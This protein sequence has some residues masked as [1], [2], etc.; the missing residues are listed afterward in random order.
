MALRK[1][2]V[3]KLQRIP[4][5]CHNT[6]RIIDLRTDADVCVTR[7]IVAI[8]S[9]L[10]ITPVLKVQDST[11]RCEH[12]DRLPAVRAQKWTGTNRVTQ[13][14]ICIARTFSVAVIWKLECFAR[15]GDDTYR[16]PNLIAV[17]LVITAEVIKVSVTFC[18][19]GISKLDRITTVGHNTHWIPVIRADAP[20]ITFKEV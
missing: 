1:A 17:A 9:T 3:V 7:D 2:C 13:E 10:R 12:T 18:L 11:I 14:V 19:A 6:Y 5:I 8:P 20:G 15:I 16:C 4:G